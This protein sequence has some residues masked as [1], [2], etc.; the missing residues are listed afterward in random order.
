MYQMQMNELKLMFCFVLFCFAV[1]RVTL[2]FVNQYW[3]FLVREIMPQAKTTIEPILIA[4]A[5]KFLLHV[6]IRKMLYYGEDSA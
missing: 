2:E 4:E 6:P 5:N 3:P 1:D